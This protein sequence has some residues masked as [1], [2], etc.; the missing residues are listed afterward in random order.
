[1]GRNK[2]NINT[3]WL[4]TTTLSGAMIST[5]ENL[6]DKEQK[7]AMSKLCTEMLVDVCVFKLKFADADIQIKS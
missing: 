5:S 2:K 1:M 4:T 6:V 7:I 3:T